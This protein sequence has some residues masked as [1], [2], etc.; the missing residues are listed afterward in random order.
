MPRLG[1]LCSLTPPSPGLITFTPKP[2]TKKEVIVI[3]TMDHPVAAAE[4]LE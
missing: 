2:D 4:M 1:A 3:H